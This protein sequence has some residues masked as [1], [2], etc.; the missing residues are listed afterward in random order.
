MNILITGAAGFIGSHLSEAL[1]QN[2]HR[3][4]G[5]DNFNDFYSPALK[6]QNLEE[7]KKTAEKAKGFF[8][9]Y[10]GRFKTPPYTKGL[11]VS[12]R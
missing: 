7:V 9:C 5:V 12:A 1:L 6:R 11:T 3:V 10:S 2:S 8:Q 4:I